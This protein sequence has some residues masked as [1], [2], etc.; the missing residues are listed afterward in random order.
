L[1]IDDVLSLEELDRVDLTFIEVMP[2]GDPNPPD[3][4]AAIW[5]FEL[6]D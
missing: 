3:R 2:L 1:V 4:V 6:E 5:V